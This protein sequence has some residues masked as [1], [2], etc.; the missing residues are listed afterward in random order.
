[1]A[2]ATPDHT[3]VSKWLFLTNNKPLILNQYD[4]HP[5]LRT[6][7]EGGVTPICRLSQSVTI[8]SSVKEK[9]LADLVEP[10][11]LGVVVI[12]NITARPEKHDAS[13]FKHF[14]QDGW[15]SPVLT[16]IQYLQTNKEREKY[17]TKRPP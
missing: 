4:N 6:I 5:L 14:E 1:M 7:V 17:V 16:F 2:E 9:S 11:F 10:L 12:E 13:N 8:E 3:F 15:L